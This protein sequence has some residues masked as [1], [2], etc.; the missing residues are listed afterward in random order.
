MSG[1]E[2]KYSTPSN[3]YVLIV[4]PEA[5]NYVAIKYF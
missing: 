2:Q 5:I 1:Y 3:K 4:K